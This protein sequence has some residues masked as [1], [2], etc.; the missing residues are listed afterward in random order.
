MVSVICSKAQDKSQSINFIS[1]DNLSLNKSLAI[2]SI[3][4]SVSVKR[5]INNFT[6][7][8]IEDGYLTSTIDSIYSDTNRV[9]VCLTAGI[10][11]KWLELNCESIPEEI[12]RNVK[13]NPTKF[14]SDIFNIN[15]LNVLKKKIINWCDNN[16]FPFAAV[17]LDSI[18]VENGNISA[19]LIL[20]GLDYYSI[21]SVHVKGDIN[22]ETSFIERFVGISSGDGYSEK[23]VNEANRLLNEIS[24]IELLRPIEVEFYDNDA[25]IFIY[26]KKRK[27]NR[28]SGLLGVLPNNKSSGKLMLTGE[29]DFYLI[30]SFGKGESLG[31][32]WQKLESSSQ[33]LIINADF[34][35]LFNSPVG[36]MYNFTLQKKDSTYLNIRNKIAVKLA[37]QGNNSVNVY[38]ERRTSSIISDAGINSLAGIKSDIAG[39]GFNY[40]RVNNILNPRN[41]YFIES[42]IGLG[43]RKSENNLSDITSEEKSFYELESFSGVYFPLKGKLIMHLANRVLWKGKNK[44]Y[45]NEMQFIG[46]NNSIRGFDEASIPVSFYSSATIELRYLY[47]QNSNVFVFFDGAYYERNSVEEFVND[48]PFGVGLGTN[49]ETK[50]GIFSLS[51]GVGKQFDNPISFSNAKIHFGFKNLF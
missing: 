34:P 9:L 45:N 41:G 39:A 46:G 19:K 49:F 8:L 11:F 17:Y 32:K 20:D 2:K 28:F 1:I 38:F 13:L 3:Q 29:V 10:Q 15:E 21:D 35:F 14:E 31:M 40:K 36:I 43:L 33:N 18:E 25:D 42:N 22:I 51:Y 16:S 47:E 5:I 26:L 27:A 44:L 7:E 6:D 30:N 48:Y 4:D 24:F 37:L 50:A 12:M 23:R